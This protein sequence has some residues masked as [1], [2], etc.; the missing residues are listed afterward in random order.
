MRKSVITLVIILALTAVL[1]FAALNGIGSI[2]PRT[3]DGIVLGLDVLGLG[4]GAPV[5]SVLTGVISIVYYYSGRWRRA[6][7]KEHGQEA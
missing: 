1:L 6:V 5:A 2:I 7:L 4:L 3:Q